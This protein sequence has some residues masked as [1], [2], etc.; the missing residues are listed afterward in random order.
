MKSGYS[1]LIIVLLCICCNTAFTQDSFV[2][3]KDFDAKLKEF[4]LE[5]IKPTEMFLHPVPHQDEYDEYDLVLYAENQKIEVRYIFRD[6]TS[7]I[8]LS[9]MPHLEF[10]RSII[11]FASNEGESNQIMIQDM[12]PETALERY[13]ADW[14]LIAD[15]TPKKSVS[16]K[17][18]G[19]ILG[20][21]KEETGLI[22]CM[23]FF[24]EELP[25]HF[26]LPIRFAKLAADLEE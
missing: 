11:D 14:C 23:V 17:P 10:Y 3:T 16:I 13:H 18:N 1:S 4:K 8:G 21:Y 20:I 6:D 26:E 15:F 19:R 24:D 22:F 9:A 12:L 25:D 2:F 5:Y 7:P